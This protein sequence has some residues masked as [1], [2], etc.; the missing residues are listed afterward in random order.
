MV[1][2]PHYVPIGAMLRNFAAERETIWMYQ[3]GG[4]PVL[5]TLENVGKQRFL[6]D[7][8]TEKGFQD[9]DG[10]AV[11][12]MALLNSLESSRELSAETRAVILS[13]VGFQAM[14]TPRA[15][16]RLNEMDQRLLIETGGPPD[17]AKTVEAIVADKSW[18]LGRMGRLGLL[19]ADALAAK[20]MTVFRNNTAVPFVLPDDPVLLVR[21]GAYPATEPQGFF[22]GH[23]I[24][25]VGSRAALFLRLPEILW[26][27][28]EQVHGTIQVREADAPLVDLL[29]T[30]LMTRA[31]RFLFARENSPSIRQ[32]FDR[33]RLDKSLDPVVIAGL[34]EP[35]AAFPSV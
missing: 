14:R 5:Q 27:R 21:N 2:H 17:A 9:L 20:T 35:P 22:Q 16:E 13:F 8:S 23:I 32:G 10:R 3:R 11:S 24:L 31:A 18:W 4:K 29:N 34:S 26:P 12:V 19:T 28:N 15:R 25:P 33:S 7:Q 6:Y 1:K 30:A